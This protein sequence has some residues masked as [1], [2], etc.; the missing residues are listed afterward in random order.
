MKAAGLGRQLIDQGMAIRVG[1]HPVEEVALDRA[2]DADLGERPAGQDV[3]GVG[4]RAF[5]GTGGDGLG[6][7][8]Q[9]GV[10]QEQP[11][12]ADR[13]AI[14]LAQQRIP[15]VALEL[16]LGLLLE[17]GPERGQPAFGAAEGQA[18]PAQ[19]AG[20]G[21]RRGVEVLALGHRG[22]EPAEQ[23][24]GILRAGPV[25]AD[26]D[27]DVVAQ[28][29]GQEGRAIGGD[30][31][32][33]RA[34]GQAGALAQVVGQLCQNVGQFAPEVRF[35]FENGRGEEGIGAAADQRHAEFVVDGA[36]RPAQAIGDE[37]GEPNPHVFM[38][39]P[40]RQLRNNAGQ[41]VTTPSA[42]HGASVTIRRTIR[43]RV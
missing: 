33:K 42:R 35:Q 39:R 27:E 23:G 38:A 22:L 16:D 19:F 26:L 31:E 37:T 9:V 32:A 10:L 2:M 14:D 40:G 4:G 34:A 15:E 1:Q 11:V 7:D 21:Q 24:F 13:R 25:L 43:K 20:D 29:E 12:L 41:G 8:G 30:A 5:Q 36:H 28:L 18:V 17:P 3:G 6:Q